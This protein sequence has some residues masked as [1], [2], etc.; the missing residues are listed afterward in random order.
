MFHSRHALLFGLVTLLAPMG[1]AVYAQD[2]GLAYAYLF[3]FGAAN[4]NGIRSFVPAPPYFAL[5]PPVYYG[6]RYTRPYGDSP[7]AS[8]PQL[9]SPANYQPTPA[10]NYA[11]AVIYAN[12]VVDPNHG[13]A[14]PASPVVR[15]I[16]TIEPLVIDNPYYR[17]TDAA[18][19]VVKPVAA[20]DQ[21]S[22]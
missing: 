17:S 14:V 6:K 8:W 21:D 22:N 12:P 19:L 4:N 13:S 2:N 3:G 7:F 11:P 20:D 18:R 9:R 5:H 15:S 16:R 1:S 10:P